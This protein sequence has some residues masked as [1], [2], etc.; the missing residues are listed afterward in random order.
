MLET[1]IGGLQKKATDAYFSHDVSQDIKTS[2][3][4][5]KKPD[6]TSRW[7]TLALLKVRPE[8]TDHS[9]TGCGFCR[10]GSY[11]ADVIFLTTWCQ[12]MFGD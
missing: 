12:S 11:H 7:P 2:V 8:Q 3:Y 6:C 1:L 10:F 9:A 4:Q 5:T